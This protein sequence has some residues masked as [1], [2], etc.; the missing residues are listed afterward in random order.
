MHGFF[1]AQ[2]TAYP[3]AKIDDG[4]AAWPFWGHS[5]QNWLFEQLNVTLQ[6]YKIV[7]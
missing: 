2:K 7:D 1:F 3:R 5:K 4:R 6:S